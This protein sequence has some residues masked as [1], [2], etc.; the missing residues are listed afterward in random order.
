LILIK[1]RIKLIQ[2]SILR[3]NT[4]EPVADSISDLGL[5]FVFWKIN[6]EDGSVEIQHSERKTNR[7]DFIVNGSILVPIH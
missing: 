4:I 3:K 6:P 2:I 1:K 7:K 5:K